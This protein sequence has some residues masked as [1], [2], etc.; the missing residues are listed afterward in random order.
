MRYLVVYYTLTAKTELIAKTI[1]AEL[2]AESEQIQTERQI[3]IEDFT[4]FNLSNLFL[5]HSITSR[6]KLKI[7]KPI[8]NVQDF[9]RIII[10][11]PVWMNNPTPAIDSYVE[12][13]NFRNK[14][15][16]IVATVAGNGS[17]QNA[18]S[19]MNSAIRKRGGRVIITQ[20]FNIEKSENS[21]IE[22][23]R[24]FAKNLNF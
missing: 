15:V 3:N 22:E 16:G 10:A 4:K 17:A 1:A 24:Q 7:N 2:N 14:E 20:E 18:F 19:V 13:Q 21:I 9:D 23:S 5:I 8:Y 11:T 6:K 12:S